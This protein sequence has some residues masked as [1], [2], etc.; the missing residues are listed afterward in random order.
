MQIAIAVPNMDTQV[1][2]GFSRNGKMP[3]ESRVVS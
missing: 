2:I 3:E 1:M